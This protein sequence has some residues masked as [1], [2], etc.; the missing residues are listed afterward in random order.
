VACF[1]TGTVMWSFPNVAPGT[2][3]L[4]V[5]TWIDQTGSIGNP[6]LLAGLE[7]CSLTAI[8][9]RVAA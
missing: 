7:N 2:H 4:A 3:A 9:V 5:F 1:P 8:V 6:D